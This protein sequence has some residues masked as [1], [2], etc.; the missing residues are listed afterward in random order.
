MAK[1]ADIVKK[2]GPVV[3][4]AALALLKTARDNPEIKQAIDNAADK[5]RKALG[6]R[7]F[8]QRIEAKLE[9]VD[10]SADT[11]ESGFPKW[12]GDVASWRT[13]VR[14]IRARLELAEA[15]A[16]G[17]QR[18]KM[19]KPLLA[20]ADDLLVEVNDRLTQINMPSGGASSGDGALGGS[21]AA[22]IE[23]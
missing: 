17:K 6:A 3:I 19:L 5:A 4:T 16:H 8:R 23:R 15:G 21:D 9:A 7:G 2:V 22:P 14:A 11:I 13:K 18:K 12:S 10:V 20:E 1:A